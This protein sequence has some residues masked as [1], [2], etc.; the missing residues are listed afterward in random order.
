MERYSRQIRRISQLA[1]LPIWKVAG[2][3]AA[4]VD[5]LRLQDDL[6]VVTS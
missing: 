2:D 4:D 5:W 3:V 1:E 6:G